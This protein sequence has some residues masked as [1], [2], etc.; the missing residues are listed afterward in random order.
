MIGD[1]IQHADWKSEKH[2]PVIECPDRVKPGEFFGVKATLGKE[3]SHPNTTEHHIRFMLVDESRHLSWL[4]GGIV[5]IIDH[6]NGLDLAIHYFH[7]SKVWTASK[8]VCHLA[9][10]IEV[11]I[12]RNSNAHY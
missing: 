8:V 5:R 7:H 4:M 12:C 3:I 1:K 10:Q 11:V 6:R 9:F 2:V